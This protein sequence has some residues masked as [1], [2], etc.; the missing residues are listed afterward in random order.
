MKVTLNDFA[1]RATRPAIVTGAARGIGAGIADSL[2]AAGHPVVLVDRNRE[3]LDE[4]RATRAD[5]TI[6][7][8]TVAADV[9]QEGDWDRI[10]LEAQSAFGPA[11]VLV[12]NAGISPKH[13]GLRKATDE[14]SLEEWNEVLAVNLTGAFLGVRAVLPDMRAQ[15][16]GRI[17]NVSSQAGRQGARIAGVHYGATK[18]ALLGVAM[19]LAY[20]YGSEGITANSLTPGRIDSDMAAH[21]PDEVNAKM[22]ASIPVGRFGQPDDIGSVIS[23]LAGDSASFITGATIDV[24]GGSYMG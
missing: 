14:M 6:R 22:M 1:I 9:S 19:T 7:V 17:V 12:N 16:W 20:E 8:A 15:R 3:A 11:A 5:V 4:F 21:A 10:M 23:F 13:N 2:L 24:N 18:S